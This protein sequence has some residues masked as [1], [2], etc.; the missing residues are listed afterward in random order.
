MKTLNIILLLIFI[1]VFTLNA[2]VAEIHL[3]N[4]SNIDQLVKSPNNKYFV[5]YDNS[6]ENISVFDVK[7]RVLRHQINKDDFSLD[8]NV[9]IKEILFSPDSSKIAIYL[10]SGI[11]FSD[12]Y[13]FIFDYENKKELGRLLLNDT[14]INISPTNFAFNN[15]EE[16]ILGG[17]GGDFYGWSY[18]DNTLSINNSIDYIDS[19]HLFLIKNIG[20]E[21]VYIVLKD[22]KLILVNSSKQEHI[23]TEEIPEDFYSQPYL[24]DDYKFEISNNHNFISLNSG[25]AI[26]FFD[27]VKGE[28][29]I[30]PNYNSVCLY[31]KPKNLEGSFTED[32]ENF[33][34]PE[35]NNVESPDVTDY[36]SVYNL[37]KKK[38]INKITVLSK[39]NTKYIEIDNKIIISVDNEIYFCPINKNKINNFIYNCGKAF[40]SFYGDSQIKTFKSNKN[41]FVFGLDNT[42]NY[43]NYST[44]EWK[45]IE[46]KDSGDINNIVIS[47]SDIL[48]LTAQNSNNGA[49]GKLIKLDLK[50]EKILYSMEMDDYK[51]FGDL[52]ISK[53]NKIALFSKR[54]TLGSYYD[55]DDIVV[56]ENRIYDIDSSLEIPVIEN[57]NYDLMYLT[58]NDNYVIAY[59][60]NIGS[61]VYLKSTF[62]YV[63]F[64]PNAFYF[65]IDGK[66]ILV[67]KNALVENETRLRRD[68]KTKVY[69]L[70]D[71]NSLIDINDIKVSNKTISFLKNGAEVL[72]INLL[73]H[74]I[75]EHQKDNISS[76]FTLENNDNK[77]YLRLNSVD[78]FWPLF[79]NYSDNIDFS[80]SD[81]LKHKFFYDVMY[82]NN[83]TLL[84]KNFW[85][86]NNWYYPEYMQE[87]GFDKGKLKKHYNLLEKSIKIN[88]EDNSSGVYENEL[89]FSLLKLDFDRPEQSLESREIRSGVGQ[90]NGVA[91]IL[92][93]YKKPII[94]FDNY[95]YINTLNE[96]FLKINSDYLFND[97]FT[98]GN[99]EKILFEV[100]EFDEIYSWIENDESKFI[101]NKITDENTIRLINKKDYSKSSNI[102]VTDS[103]EFIIF[104][105]DNY[106]MASKGIFKYIWFLHNNKVYRPEQ[107]DLKYNRPD[108]V[109][110]RLGKADSTT[111][112][113]Y[114][115]QYKKRLKKMGV[116]YSVLED[117]LNIPEIIIKNKED[118]PAFTSN[119]ILKL[120]LSMWDSK[121]DLNRINVWIN[122]TPIYGM[123]GIDISTLNVKKINKEITLNLTKGENKIQLSVL[124]N[125]GVE[126]LKETVFIESTTGKEKPDLYLISIG[127][128]DYKNSDFNLKYAAKDA[129]DV[130]SQF[131]KSGLYGKI[132]TKLLTNTEVTIE[133]V[134]ALSNFLQS[135]DIDDVVMV[136]VASHGLLDA[137]YNYFLASYDID[138]N[139]PASKGIPFDLLEAQLDNIAPLKKMMFVDACHSG[140]VD[141]DEVV[142]NAE[143]K[144][145]PVNSRGSKGKL[146]KTKNK[147]LDQIST[148]S[149]LLFSDLRRG[150]G[151][152]IISSAGG[153][154][155]AY[156]GEKWQNGL[157]TY[158]MLNGISTQK[159][160]LNNDGEIMLSELQ[161]YVGE[162][163]LQLSNGKQQP[164]SRI[165][166]ISVDYRV[167]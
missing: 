9:I 7:N 154:E 79:L 6:R 85:K 146:L 145:S 73:S 144:D 14:S 76:L 94:N 115:Y 23:I 137:E 15:N 160:D 53:D 75:I 122:D 143:I 117:D 118:L 106:Y 134:G 121:N 44:G 167:W 163:V 139:A 68:D 142:V 156:E 89:L 161:A 138:F 70:N 112:I 88:Y 51:W 22:K 152:T 40:D 45:T 11:K 8:E 49:S 150:N 30:I 123:N 29:H 42:I 17:Y 90:Q 91:T 159:A 129:S 26:K 119:N 1:N 16:L 39:E 54:L 157:F 41:Y 113:A 28:E 25:Y 84:I 27:L 59:K 57:N 78:H 34:F 151:T 162:Q 60:E 18:I 111:V 43:F 140:E 67:Q 13:I 164:T 124:N 99:T 36:I 100:T 12:S 96:H 136:F 86:L 63:D 38:R 4:L 141:V 74:E 148:L 107:F 135:A 46:I 105:D 81:K 32:N 95:Y 147:S 165:E 19:F 103:N 155:F 20:N 55:F 108:I 35:K 153:M 10:I 132:H 66:K 72:N 3:N 33:I 120:K 116:D 82:F 52:K 48:F 5:T 61:Y 92:L 149:K 128:S 65:L 50:S 58:N 110:N 98:E 71:I 93:N 21:V 56:T 77:L 64:K 130:V 62:E 158:C 97:T 104:F 127:V 133:S 80:N 37:N 47:S 109:L 125:A 131:S 87:G 2:Q 126:S 31:C 69:N 24:K 102:I 83:N 114:N 166:N 101:E